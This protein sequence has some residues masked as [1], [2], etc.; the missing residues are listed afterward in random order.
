MLC[1]QPSA[2]THHSMDYSCGLCDEQARRH[3]GANTTFETTL[4]RTITSF[5]WAS[6]TSGPPE[7]PT[8]TR[9]HRLRTKQTAPAAPKSCPPPE[10]DLS[11]WT[12]SISSLG[13][14]SAPPITLSAGEPILWRGGAFAT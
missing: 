9:K 3:F 7:T 8:D 10:R 14:W 12:R 1:P 4:S 13:R 11:G 2:L 6:G 5:R